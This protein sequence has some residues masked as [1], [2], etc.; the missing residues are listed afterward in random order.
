MPSLIEQLEDYSDPNTMDLH[1]DLARSDWVTDSDGYAIGYPSDLDDWD[2]SQMMFEYFRIQPWVYDVEQNHPELGWMHPASSTYGS[3][4]DGRDVGDPDFVREYQASEGDSRGP[5]SSVIF[6]PQH[7]L[8]LTVLFHLFQNSGPLVMGD[9]DYLLPSSAASIEMQT[10]FQS[11]GPYTIGDLNTVLAYQAEQ[12]LNVMPLYSNLANNSQVE[13]TTTPRYHPIMPLLA[14]PGWTYDDG[15]PVEKDAWI[16][17]VEVQIT[18]GLDLFENSTGIRPSGMWPSE[19][20]VS[21]SIVSPMAENGIQWAI[22]DKQVLAQSVKSDGSYP[23]ESSTLDITSP[24]IVESDGR[25]IMM[26]FRETGISDRISFSYGDM[27]ADDAV[28]DFISEVENRRQE[29]IDSGGDPTQHLLTVA[30]DGE[31]WLFMSGFGSTDNGREFMHTWFDALQDHPTIRT[32]TPGEYL[33][34][35]GKSNMP[36]LQ[37]LGTG[38]WVQG[39]LSTWAGEEEE[40]IG[41]HRLVAARN[42]YME[43]L[44]ENPSHEGLPAARHALMAAQGSD[45]FWWYGADQDS[46]D[47]TQFDALFRTHLRTI[48]ES[49][50][51]SLPPDLLD[52]TGYVAAPDRSAS[53]LMTPYYDGLSFPGEWSASA[54][55]DT[56]GSG[57]VGITSIEVGHDTNSIHLKVEVQDIDI[58]LDP[59]EF[60]G[61]TPHMQIYLMEA[62]AIDNNVVKANFRTYYGMEP[63]NMPT[64][65]MLWFDFDELRQDGRMTYNTFH[66][67]GNEKWSLASQGVLGLVHANEVF[68]IE[69]PWSA[70]DLEPNGFTRLQVV[71]SVYQ[72]RAQGQGT[73][74][75]LAPTPSIHVQMPDVESWVRILDMTDPK[76]DEKGD[77]DYTYPL[78]GDFSPQS[79]LFDIER[80]IID[81]SAWNVRFTIKMAEISNGWNMM[82]GWSHAN[83]QI[84]VDSD[85]GGSRDLFPGTY[86][87]THPDWGWESAVMLVGEPGPV[88]GMRHDSPTRITT[89]IEARGDPETDTIIATVSKTILSGDLASSRFLIVVGSQDGYGEGKLRAVDETASTWTAGERAPSNDENK[90]K[91]H[92]T[93]WDILLPPEVNQEEML[94]SYDVSLM[95][96]AELSGIELPPV[97]QQVY[98]LEI[99]EISGS[100]AVLQWSSAKAGIMR[101]SVESG[102]YSVIDEEWTSLGSDHVFV[103]RG[104]ESGTDYDVTVSAEDAELEISFSTTLE[105]DLDP[106]VLMGADVETDEGLYLFS[107]YTTE[108]ASVMI[109]VCTEIGCYDA[110]IESGHYPT[111]QIHDYD[112]TVPDG[113]HTIALNVTDVAGNSQSTVIVEIGNIGGGKGDGIDDSNEDEEEGAASEQ[114]QDTQLMSL[115]IILATLVLLWAI[116]LRLSSRSKGPSGS[117]P[118]YPEK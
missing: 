114:D 3:L 65:K 79:G 82:W 36:R 64:T 21:Q 14:M 80:V 88:Y 30:A 34:E 22:S 5:K 67:E 46:G 40:T 86:A 47:D 78:A 110:E 20:A 71:S 16:E 105:R 95:R 56:N 97:K 42:A 7:L 106:P 18:E 57:E 52:L 104:L 89:G 111:Q 6:H 75:D 48:Y 107:F 15:I 4:K 93:I 68:E 70:A 13:L 94:A 69:I 2:L 100:S 113:N 50:G 66:S 51:L 38:S 24:W 90:Q 116:I 91:Y 87:T 103:L 39:D 53:G 29:I 102:G 109:E 37:E 11:Q 84:Y 31:N 92:S 23:S 44:A 83:I 55:Y 8:D 17:D 77:G 32:I 28:A 76:G 19:Q 58:F 9:Y 12:M 45:W 60:E 26:I 117:L 99:G 27:P 49:L 35:R 96:Y 81:Q 33:Q 54:H 10:L 63:L 101:V 62:N 59:N 1:L 41:W 115:P 112:L 118:N 98:G 85:N 25:E 74:I 72:S 108:P 43:V 61:G 73:D